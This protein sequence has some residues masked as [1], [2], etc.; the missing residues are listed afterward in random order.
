LPEQSAFGR[1]HRVGR[2]EPLGLSVATSP[3]D[4]ASKKAQR[5]PKREHGTRQEFIQLHAKTVWAT[6]FF[7]E[8]VWTLR[9]PVTYYLLLFI[10]LRTR[11]VHVAGMTSNPDGAWMSKMA[12]NMSMIFAEEKAE[13]RPTHIIRGRD[14]KYTAEFRSVLES[15]GIE[16][17]PIPARCP[18]L[19]PHSEVWVRRVKEECMNHFI[20][21]GESHLRHIMERWPTYYHKSCPHQGLGNVPIDYDLPPPAPLSQFKLEDVVCHES[22]GGLLRHYERRAA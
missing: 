19:N 3:K 11:R 7:S 15:D 8:T 13:F 14:A 4:Q 2:L 5:G 12:R 22:L 21:F 17:R 20:V 9:G 18:N 1:T 6:D 16:F 10:H